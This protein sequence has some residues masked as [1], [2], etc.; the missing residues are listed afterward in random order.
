MQYWNEHNRVEKNINA[1]VKLLSPIKAQYQLYQEVSRTG[2]LHWHGYLLF[3]EYEQIT[4]FYVHDVHRLEMRSKIEVD[5]IKDL[6][7][8]EEYIQK[9][10]R[11][12]S[13][14][15]DNKIVEEQNKKQEKF[16]INVN[17]YYSTP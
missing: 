17:K 16:T 15:L 10:R 7:K 9:Q 13:G 4:S 11:I 8:W 6:N 3:T 1:T 12:M 5:T 14:Y 2:R